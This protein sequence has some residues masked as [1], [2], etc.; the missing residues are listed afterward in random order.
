MDDFNY[1][2][3]DAVNSITVEAPKVLQ[4]L[5]LR[6]IPNRTYVL[7]SVITTESS[8]SIPLVRMSL[9]D[10]S[11]MMELQRRLLTTQLPFYFEI[12]DADGN[13][14]SLYANYFDGEYK[15]KGVEPDDELV[16]ATDA[17]TWHKQGC[18]EEKCQKV[19]D[20]C[21]PWV[22]TQEDV[23]IANQLMLRQIVK[24]GDANG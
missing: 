17:L 19:I 15:H 11:S 14:A 7:S 12:Q 23:S 10:G 24:S 3:L 9:A 8:D 20:R 2:A 6:L 13:T 4:E 21:E 1:I 22:F 16:A 18:L 5:I